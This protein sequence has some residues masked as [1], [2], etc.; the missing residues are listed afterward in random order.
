MSM[1][2]YPPS[3]DSNNYPREPPKV[4]SEG[5]LPTVAEIPVT[6]Y[7]VGPPLPY[8]R[9]DTPWANWYTTSTS[10]VFDG[11]LLFLVSDYVHSAYVLCGISASL[12]RLFP[13][14]GHGSWHQGEKQ[15]PATV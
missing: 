3:G 14:A 9:W 4:K 13:A 11:P 6:V 12:E 5:I 7:P 10:S 2:N 8:P 15:K 1:F